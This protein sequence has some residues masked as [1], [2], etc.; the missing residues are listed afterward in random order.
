MALHSMPVVW[1]NRVFLPSVAVVGR[2]GLETLWITF[3]FASFST[4]FAKL[5]IFEKYCIHLRTLEPNIPVFG[6]CD[7]LFP[8]LEALPDMQPD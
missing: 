5:W 2:E 3:V 6:V 4:S 7:S 1:Q 8:V